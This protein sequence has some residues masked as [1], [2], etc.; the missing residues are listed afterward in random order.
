MSATIFILPTVPVVRADEP[1]PVSVRI[2]RR[3][4]NRLLRQGKKWSMGVEEMTLAAVDEYL[5][6]IAGVK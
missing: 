3:Q 2:P 1:V 5:K 4:Y 6:R